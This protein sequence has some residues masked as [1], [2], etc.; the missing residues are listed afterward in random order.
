MSPS[1]RDIHKQ[2]K[3]A[4][5]VDSIGKILKFYSCSDECKGFCCEVFDIDIDIIEVEEVIKISKRVKNTLLNNIKQIG[6]EVTYLDTYRLTTKPCPFLRNAKCSIY[7]K[8]PI[9][10]KIYP[11]RFHKEALTNY[12]CIDPCPMGVNIIFDW[13]IWSISKAVLSNVE[14]DVV[15]EIIVENM[16]AMLL[17]LKTVNMF[18]RRV[19]EALF[20]SNRQYFS[21]D[22]LLLDEFTQYLALVPEKRRIESRENVLRENELFHQYL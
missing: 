4:Q 16:K 12:V 22:S 9:P 21:V 8:R 13:C 7:N 15:N 20:N 6:Q 14:S 18:K 2:L 10:C 19:V 11:F 3:E 1:N 17:A 5:K